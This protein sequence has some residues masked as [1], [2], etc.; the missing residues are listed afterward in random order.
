MLAF[1]GADTIAGL[2]MPRFFGPGAERDG[3]RE[4]LASFVE[5]RAARFEGR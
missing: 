3:G 1:V 4:G 5:R 2:D